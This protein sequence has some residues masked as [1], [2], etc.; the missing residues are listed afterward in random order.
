MGRVCVGISGWH[1]AGWRGDFYPASLAQREELSYAAERLGSIESNGTFYRLQKP[2][3]WSASLRANEERLDGFLDMLPKD[4]TAAAELAREHDHRV[5][6]PVMDFD[7]NRRVR[8]ALDI[9]HPSWFTPEVVRIARRHGVAL[10]VSSAAEWEYTDEL[11][12]GFVYLR[13][14]GSEETYTSRHSDRE[15]NRLAE[16]I[17]AWVE[18]GEPEDA[19]RITDLTPPRRKSRDVY[20]Y[21]DND[22][23]VHAPRDALRLQERLVSSWPDHLTVADGSELNSG[24]TDKRR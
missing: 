14:H 15:L 22:R 17:R 10:V 4:F 11:T 19:A 12:A 13:M 2:D 7:A 24:M 1:Y 20:V 23:K 6:E 9:R 8:H 3:S 21:F 5:P 16:R 18:G